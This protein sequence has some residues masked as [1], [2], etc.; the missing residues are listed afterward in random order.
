M[1][2]DD[3]QNEL[4]V[5]SYIVR[6]GKKILFWDLPQEERSR[7]ATKWSDDFM[8]A[9]GYVPAESDLE[10]GKGGLSE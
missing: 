9:L 4:K 6:D 5:K 8:F 1:A 10:K 2:R 3:A 7:L